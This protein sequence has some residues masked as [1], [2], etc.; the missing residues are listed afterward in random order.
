M[1]KKLTA[2]ILISVV[3][4]SMFCSCSSNNDKDSL[5]LSLKNEVSLSDI[6]LGYLYINEEPSLKNDIEN[7]KKALFLTDKQIIYKKLSDI[8]TIDIAI[9]ELSAVGCNV[10]ITDSSISSSA[11][12]ASVVNN[13]N[14]YFILYGESSSTHKNALYYTTSDLEYCFVLGVIAAKRSETKN[15][16]ILNAESENN[17][18]YYSRVNAFALGVNL[19]FPEIKIP[20]ST[21]YNTLRKDKCD[22]IFAS[23]T[24]NIQ[25]AQELVGIN[26]ENI[27]SSAN[28]SPNYSEFITKML[29]DISNGTFDKRQICVGT[30]Y[31]L[32]DTSLDSIIKDD[33][34]RAEIKA[35]INFFNKGNKLFTNNELLINNGEI[36]SIN[37]PITD[38]RG[39]KMTDDNGIYYYYKNSDGEL[40]ESSDY[41]ALISRDM[42]YYVK[43]IVEK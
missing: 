6:I 10:I 37:L 16:G 12:D 2:V 24:P 20:V 14:K 1:Y 33:S 29:I 4:L 32:Y 21:N 40:S 30:N 5:Q 39:N 22:A 27:E 25:D 34:E 35:I 9:K 28:L 7:V 8:D 3:L 36:V 42:N 19:I 17:A 26:L 43:N 31:A 15:I 23:S 41:H 11:L 13:N 38:N 18:N